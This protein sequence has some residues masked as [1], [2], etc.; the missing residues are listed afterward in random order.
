MEFLQGTTEPL[1]GH[2]T[3]P[4]AKAPAPRRARNST[5]RVWLTAVLAVLTVL[6][7][8][9]AAS[10]AMAEAECA[11]EPNPIVCENSKP[12][13]PQSEWDVSGAG[14][15]SIQGF[16]TDIS[17]N[18]GQIVDFKIDTPSSAYHLD[19]YRMGYYAGDGARKVATVQPSAALPQTQPSCLNEPTTGL[20]DCGNWSVSASWAVPADAVSG[21][22]FAKLVRTDVASDGSH[23]Y[24]IVRDDGGKSDVLF[25]TSDT[26]WQAYNRY[27]GNSLYASEGGSENETS[28]GRAYKVSYNRP[29]TTRGT[30][31][32][33]APFNAEYPMVRFLE[34]NGYDVS[35]FTGVDADRRGSEILNHKVYLSVGHDEYWSGAQRANVEAAR[36]AGVN[37]AF[38]SGNEVFWRTRWENSIDPSGT[39]HRTLVSYKETHANEKI[40]PFSL[41]WTGTWRDPRIFNPE[42][43]HP[44]NALTGTIFMVNSGTSAIKVPAAE[45][46]LR[47]WRNTSIANL[48]PTETATLTEGT[49]G[50]EWDEDLDNGFRPAGLIDLSST[51]LSVEKLLDY[52]S[53]YGPGQ[54]ATHHLTL[55]R[56]PSGALVFGA[57]T[58]QWSW[59][60]D[61][62]HDRGEAAADPRMQQAT[63]N[64]L[65]DMHTQPATLQGGLV[66]AS[67]ST[68]TQP[69]SATISTP[70]GESSVQ[71]G[72]PITISGS[73]TDTTGETGGGQV[74]GVE[75]S[76]DGGTSWHPAQGTDAWSYTW[77]PGAVGKATI[78]ARA[79]R[80]QRQPREP[81]RSGERQRHGSDL[82]LLDLG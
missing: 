17:V 4:R 33:D 44:E 59:G 43:P 46:K 66:A 62:Q 72:Q 19:I 69:P 12:G 3:A 68:D 34:R 1:L 37:L 29:I 47:L 41:E 78:E 77:T 54:Q 18:H 40:D 8:L 58:V 76:T 64:L 21:I 55:Y 73:A 9:S 63:V 67:A 53:T 15:P 75:V 7:G 61:S 20:V 24:F 36:A 51:T 57:G 2:R 71:S 81:G 56:A 11:S 6:V 70:T 65:A 35:Y 10:P 38:F 23:I 48:A 45:G 22:Y 28:S 31:S 14:D 27:G 80:R 60:L 30:S 39:D 52:G 82:P 74:A 50:Y 42:G 79:T 13:N 25:Q 26:T 49:L 32:E 16:A 5:H